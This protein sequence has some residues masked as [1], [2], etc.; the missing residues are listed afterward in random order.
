LKIHFDLDNIS[1]LPIAA[2]TT[3]TF[4]GVHLGHHT[5]INRLKEAAQAIGGES[6]LLTFYP[7][8][9]L[10]L[11]PLDTEIKLLNSQQ[12]KE[13][14]LS[15]T[16]IDHLVVLPFTKEFSRLTSLDFVRNILVNKLHA[17]KLVIGY[18]H[19]FGRNRE[20]SFEHLVEFGPMYGFEVEEIPALDVDHV[21][22]S[23]SK[24]RKALEE[25]DLQTANTFLGYPYFITGKVIKGKQL[26]NSIGFPTANIVIEDAYKLIPANGVYAVKIKYN[27][28]I[29][30][31]MMNIGINPTVSESKSI[32]IE[33]NIF[34][35]NENI[36]NKE[37]VIE[38][39]TKLRD[40]QKFEN[41]Q[42]LINQLEQDKM[43]AVLQ[44][45]QYSKNENL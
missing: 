1:N 16:G 8:P 32:K 11:F 41:V 26:G 21:A 43:H 31:G 29:Y 10:V 2:V 24:I 3:G 36:Y 23:S 27:H 34:D 25:G 37:I 7:H 42:Q 9:R 14:L 45:N 20:G 40:E 19:H 12:E 35:F 4:D 38:L 5:I 30:N 39:Y 18:D 17:K 22:I 33:V 15:K 44:L 28:G 13:F 6:V